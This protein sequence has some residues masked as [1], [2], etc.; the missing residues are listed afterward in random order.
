MEREKDRMKLRKEKERKEKERKK[1][2]KKCFLGQKGSR[3]EKIFVSKRSFDWL[4]LLICYFDR[5]TS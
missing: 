4:F 2:G 5:S 1:R 3:T